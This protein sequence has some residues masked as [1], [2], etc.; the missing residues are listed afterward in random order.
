MKIFI[1][2]ILFTCFLGAAGVGWAQLLSERAGYLPID[3]T[4]DVA[5]FKPTVDVNIPKFM[6]NEVVDGLNEASKNQLAE[7]GIDL[8]SVIKEIHRIRI[9]VFEAG[10]ETRDGLETAVEALRGK[11]GSNWIPLVRVVDDEDKVDVCVASDE[12]GEKMGGLCFIVSDGSD[13][14]IG[15]IVGRVPLGALINLA[16]QADALPQD[17]I[18]QIAAIAEGSALEGIAEEMEEAR[19]TGESDNSEPEPET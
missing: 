1:R 3:E 5:A 16:A 4:V 11:L 12:S 6:L 8:Y 15:N 7:A 18:K 19:S 13:F 10:E 2:Y 17:L 14:V 9:V